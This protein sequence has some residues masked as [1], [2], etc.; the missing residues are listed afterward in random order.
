MK[1]RKG[2][3]PFLMKYL[4]VLYKSDYLSKNAFDKIVFILEIEEKENPQ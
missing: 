4:E 3:Y 2:K 1:N